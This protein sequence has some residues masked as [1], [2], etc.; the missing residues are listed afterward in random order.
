MSNSTD[1]KH[2]AI[3]IEKAPE[4]IDSFTWHGAIEHIYQMA[5]DRVLSWATAEAHD[6][7]L[8][9]ADDAIQEWSGGRED[10]T[11][12]TGRELLDRAMADGFDLQTLAL[13]NLR[14]TELTLNYLGQDAAPYVREIL[15]LFSKNPNLVRSRNYFLTFDGNAGSVKHPKIVE[16][17]VRPD[18]D[19]L[20]QRVAETIVDASIIFKTV[21]I[22][23]N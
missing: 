17:W 16:P 20:S 15:A 22:E 23:F 9:A 13:R 21:T 1:R 19:A 3:L 18:P 7:A 5:V 4:F 8:S 12:P 14:V 2:A 10:A 11:A 6:R